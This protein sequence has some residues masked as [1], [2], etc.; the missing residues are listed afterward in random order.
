MSAVPMRRVGHVTHLGA[1]ASQVRTKHDSPW[2]LV[3]ELLA[4]CLETVLEELEVA[5]TA[6]AALLVLELIL[7]NEWLVAELDGLGEGRRDGVVGSLGL[8][9]ETLVADDDGFQGLLDLPLADIAPS[10]ATNS[11][12]LGCF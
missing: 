12:L 1:R 11:G 5:T 2:S 4:S 3:R 7:H 8:R 6:V 10:L 9:Y